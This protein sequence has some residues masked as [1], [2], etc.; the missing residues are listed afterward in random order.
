[1][2][3]SAIQYEGSAPF[4][5]LSKRI[6]NESETHPKKTPERKK[7]GGGG[8]P[9]TRLVLYGK[10]QSRGMPGFA[11]SSPAERGHPTQIRGFSLPRR[12]SG[13]H[14]YA[15]ANSLKL[16]LLVLVALVVLVVLLV[17]VVLVVVG[18]VVV[19]AVVVAV[20]VVVVLLLVVLVILV[21]SVTSVTSL[22]STIF[23]I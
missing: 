4:A 22:H 5:T 23:L 9:I 15:K 19:V 21:R 8:G 20:V 12:S 10:R 1:M 17:L 16:L 13:R 18:V 6:P 3:P 7:G 14:S 11:R 2:A